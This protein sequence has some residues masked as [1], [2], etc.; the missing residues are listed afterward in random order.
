MATKKPVL[1]LAGVPR[2]N[3]LPRLEVER[4][5]R[6]S[7][8]RTW[9]LLALASLVV[10]VLVIG[11][12]FTLKLVADQQLV[13]EQA[14]TTNLLTE[15]QSYSDVSKAISTQGEL[16]QFRATAMGTDTDW[17]AMLHLVTGATPAGVTMLEFTLNPAASVLED[18]T[19]GVGY[20]GLLTFSAPGADAQAATVRALRAVPGV[21]AVDAAT[22]YQGGEAGFEFTVT[23]AFDQSVFTGAYKKGAQN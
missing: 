22:L 1:A 23:I 10:G 19:S 15:L 6:I 8:T 9:V 16:E 17:T 18:P 12:A 20:S 3:L 7:L 21:L 13:A 4:R 14:R 11:G 5:E 2:I